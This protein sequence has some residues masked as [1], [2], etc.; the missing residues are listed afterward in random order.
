MQMSMKCFRKMN[1]LV[2][3]FY[4]S[5]VQMDQLRLMLF[6]LVDSRLLDV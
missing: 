5:C 1:E 6:T 3:R 4:F 2:T